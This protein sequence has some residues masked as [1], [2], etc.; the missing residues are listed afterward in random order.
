MRNCT[1]HW[2]RMRLGLASASLTTLLL[3]SG[4]N[5]PPLRNKEPVAPPVQYM[6]E[7]AGPLYIDPSNRG[8]AQYA[9]GLKESLTFCNADKAA[10]REWEALWRLGR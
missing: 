1:G 8:L 9:L 6:Q 10:L 4:C 2:S 3:L 5:S 7:T